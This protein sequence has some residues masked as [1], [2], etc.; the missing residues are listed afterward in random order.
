MSKLSNNLVDMKPKLLA[1]FELIVSG[2]Q[3]FMANG[4]AVMSQCIADAQAGAA[5]L[6][7]Q[8]GDGLNKCLN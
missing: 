2:F 5:D 7:K 6:A 3:S 1:E 4:K 8:L